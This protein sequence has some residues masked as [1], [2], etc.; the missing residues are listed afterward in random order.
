MPFSLLSPRH[1]GVILVA[2]LSVFLPSLAW[3]VETI[4]LPADPPVHRTVALEEVWRVGGDDDGILLGLVT[5]GVLGDDSNVFLADQQL[6]HVLVI[7]PDGEILG[8]L[9]R[10]GEGPG[11]LRRL[12]SVF[13]AGER[14]GMV[15]GF[16]GKVVYLDREGLPAGGFSAGDD[17][18]QGGSF[19]I[20]DLHSMGNVLVAQMS[21]SSQDLEA[22]TSSTRTTLSVYNFD[23]VCA[24]DLVLHEVARGMRQVV[25]DEAA[26]WAE[27]DS[28]A[29]SPRG[30]VATVAER[31]AWA[32]NEWSLTGELLRVLHRPCR[33]RKRTTLEKEEAVSRIRL[34]AVMAD[35]TF[36]KKPLDTDPAVVDLQ[37][38]DDGHLF[39]TTCHNAPEQLEMGVAGCFDVIS[40]AGEFLEELTFTFPDHDPDQ[41]GLV[42]LDGTHFLILRNYEDA[43]KAIYA[44][45]LS[46]EEREGLSDAEPLE[47]I[48]V[49]IAS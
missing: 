29:V 46:E 38:A 19:A 1:A 6:T 41:D 40:P 17:V 27:F 43:E 44:A 4:D 5:S 23:G 15:Q 2:V 11:E 48:L 3:S 9:G 33:P 35:A 14:V 26:S 24:A 22:G 16:P 42:F 31:D 20:R 25:I 10:E 36:D 21:R 18:A 12:Q 49:R 28:W 45:F 47:V 30:I 8:T 32:V 39:V 34:S 13:V 7:S 37:Y